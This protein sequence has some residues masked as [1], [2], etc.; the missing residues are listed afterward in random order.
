MS[1]E[2]VEVK[3]MAGTK[4][5]R[6]SGAPVTVNALSKRISRLTKVL[7]V[8]NPHHVYVSALSAAF[9]NLSTTGSIYEVGAN[10]TQGRS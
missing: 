9:T 4:R 8:A 6:Y 5:R 7:K 1:D 10:I 2:V 3:R